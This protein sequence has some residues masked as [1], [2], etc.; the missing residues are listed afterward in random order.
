[1]EVANGP[2][3]SPPPPACCRN[4]EESIPPRS[5][6]TSTVSVG[7]RWGPRVQPLPEAAGWEQSLGRGIA[8]FKSP[9]YLTFG[10]LRWL[11]G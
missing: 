3:T 1:M 4:D 8:A 7:D 2:L 6:E 5:K 11:N 10:P 9:E